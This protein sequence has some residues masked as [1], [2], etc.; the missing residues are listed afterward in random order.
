MTSLHLQVSTHI[1]RSAAAIVELTGVS[2][3]SG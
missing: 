1:V 3:W 2:V